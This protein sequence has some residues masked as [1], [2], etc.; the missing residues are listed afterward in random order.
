[1]YIYICCF[2]SARS[3]WSL[4]ACSQTKCNKYFFNFHRIFV[5]IA[6]INSMLTET[7]V[8]TNC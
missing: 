5:L 8:N 3:P 4:Y 2:K 6:N 7:T 1:M